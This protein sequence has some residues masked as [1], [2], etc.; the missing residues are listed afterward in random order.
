MNWLAHPASA[1]AFAGVHG[2]IVDNRVARFFA[3]ASAASSRLVESTVLI[4]VGWR[5]GKALLLMSSASPGTSSA[6]TEVVSASRSRTVLRYSREVRRRSGS[7][8]AA[9]GSAAIVPPP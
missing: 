8:P 6:A 5:N 7:S 3:S 4:D 2:R 1:D 9:F